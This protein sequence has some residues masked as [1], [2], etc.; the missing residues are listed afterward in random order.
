M[1][2]SRM[3]TSD[4]PMDGVGYDQTNDG[5]DAAPEA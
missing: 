4:E 3:S 1:R 2:M 5:V